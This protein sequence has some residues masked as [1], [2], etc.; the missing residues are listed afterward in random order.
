MSTSSIRE[1]R[2]L[3]AEL[4]EAGQHDAARRTQRRITALERAEDES[5]RRWRQQ[6]D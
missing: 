1:L 4:L 6:R 3:L 2:R 5:T